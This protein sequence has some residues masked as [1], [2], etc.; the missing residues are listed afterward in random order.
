V[1]DRVW[2]KARL[3]RSSAQTNGLFVHHVDWGAKITVQFSIN[4]KKLNDIFAFLGFFDIT[5][6]LKPL[7]EFADQTIDDQLADFNVND[8]ND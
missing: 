1:E 4:N 8:E 6:G 5:S 2:K 3:W 7:G